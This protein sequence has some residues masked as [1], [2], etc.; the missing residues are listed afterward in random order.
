MSGII[1]LQNIWTDLNSA[2]RLCKSEEQQQYLRQVR[3]AFH[4]NLFL[5]ENPFWQG[6][7]HTQYEDDDDDSDNV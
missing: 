6:A 1:K 3:Y 7:A 4:N 2:K 5:D